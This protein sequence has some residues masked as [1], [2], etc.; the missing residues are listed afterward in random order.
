MFDWVV[1]MK[2]FTEVWKKVKPLKDKVSKLAK[3]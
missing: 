2:K 3:E 1:A